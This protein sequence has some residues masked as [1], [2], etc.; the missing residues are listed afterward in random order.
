MS[1]AQ[2][3]FVLRRAAHHAAQSGDFDERFPAFVY[4]GGKSAEGVPLWA[5]HPSDAQVFEAV[6]AAREMLPGRLG[7]FGMFVPMQLARSAS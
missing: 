2:E 3:H 4:F 5:V 6:E 7:Q 1:Q